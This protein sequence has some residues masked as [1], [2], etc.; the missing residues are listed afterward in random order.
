[1]KAFCT[2]VFVC[3]SLTAFACDT[4]VISTTTVQ[5]PDSFVAVEPASPI[6][7][8]SLPSALP[9]D[10]DLAADKDGIE[11]PLADA[12]VASVPAAEPESLAV[13]ALP[14]EPLLN[15]P[16]DADN[17]D[18]NDI[19][20]SITAP[21][22]PAEDEVFDEF[23]EDSDELAAAMLQGASV[24]ESLANLDPD[25]VA[26][27]DPAQTQDA[28]ASENQEDAAGAVEE[29]TT[30]DE[31]DNAAAQSNDLDTAVE[32]DLAPAPDATIERPATAA[33]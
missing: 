7:P 18:R 12:A 25:D 1:M 23:I 14:S 24:S 17:A 26:Y 9:A 13:A 21:A 33:E 22:A 20:G 2:L 8:L 3:T 31:Q 19:T 6:E 16:L 10:Q 4:A 5:Q 15:E 11:T 27:I 28:A 32:A 29:E 30:I